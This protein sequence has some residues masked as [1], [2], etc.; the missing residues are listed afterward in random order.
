LLR[1]QAAAA[2]AH[3]TTRRAPP[4]PASPPPSPPR[5]PAPPPPPP[6]PRTLGPPGPA[7]WLLALRLDKFV[8][9]MAA[10]GVREVVD[11]AEARARPL[12]FRSCTLRFCACMHAPAC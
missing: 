2:A 11:F 12:R 4:R 5:S 1:P 7:D 9:P 10:L 8:A 6:P 3:S